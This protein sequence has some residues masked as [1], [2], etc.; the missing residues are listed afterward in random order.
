MADLAAVER[1]LRAILEPYRSR[2]A[3][4]GD[5]PKG[6]A[7]HLRGLEVQ[8]HGFVAGV[9]P[10]KRYVSFY[11]MPVY[12]FPEL[13]QDMSPELRRRMQG[14]SCFNFTTVDQ[15]LIAELEALTAQGPDRYEA[16]AVTGEGPLTAE[17]FR[18]AR[19]VPSPR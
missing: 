16:A 9:R 10:G 18:P 14:K 1:R 17:R 15:A 19:Q 6:V 5:G 8:P 12:A 7:L 13:G 2:F 3:V 11:L 4:V